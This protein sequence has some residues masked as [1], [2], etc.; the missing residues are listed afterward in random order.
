M[1]RFSIFLTPT[2]RFR[3][4][5]FLQAACLLHHLQPPNTRDFFAWLLISHAIRFSIQFCFLTSANS[6]NG[7]ALFDRHNHAVGSTSAYLKRRFFRLSSVS[8]CLMFDTV[9]SVFNDIPQVRC[10]GLA[11]CACNIFSCICHCHHSPLSPCRPYFRP[12][13]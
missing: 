6:R 5:E 13:N 4:R 7:E 2:P 3:Q 1:G 9:I 10:L 8:T 12:A 11:A